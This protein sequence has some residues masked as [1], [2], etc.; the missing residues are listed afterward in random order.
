[1]G[2]TTVNANADA[3]TWETYAGNADTAPNSMR[4]RYNNTI[5]MNDWLMSPPM[6]FTTPHIYK[7]KFAYRANSATY[8]EK[9]TVYYGNAP[10]AAAMT[11]VI[12]E[13]LNITNVTYNVAEINIPIATSGTYYIG[14]WG[15]SAVD[16]FYIYLDTF[17]VS[18]ILD[19]I[20]PPLNLTATIQNNNNVHLAWQ[21]P[22]RALLGYK[23]YRDAALIATINNPA[24]LVYDDNAL[25]VG[26]YSYTVTAYYDGGESTPAGPVSVTIVPP[27]N[28]PTNLTAT[29]T[30]NDV[31]LNWTSPEA[32]PQGTWITWSQDVLGN[33]VGTNAAANFDVAHRWPVADIAPYV[34]QTISQVKFVPSEAN[35]VYTVKIWTGGSVTA[36]ATLVTSQV[37][38]NPTIDDW[39]LVVLNT[40]VTI[41]ANSEV[42]IGYNCNTQAGYPAGC[43]NGPQIENKGNMIY[44]SGSWS[45]LTALAPT[46]TYN[47]T[48]QGFVQ[49]STGMKAIT[50]KPVAEFASPVKNSGC[51]A[52]NHRVIEP[53]R[54]RALTG[55]KVYRDNVLVGT[56][57]NPT[58]T[59]FAE[60]DLP[61]ATYIYGVT[62]TY[63][64][65]E[66]V[67]ATVQAVVNV[68]LA[69]AFFTETFETYP[70][71]ATLF[72][73]WTLLDQDQSATYA[74]QN[75]EFP[76]SAGPM[77]FIIFNPSATTPPVTSVAAHGGAKMAA[78]FASTTPPNND[79][80]ITP[81]VHLGTTSAVKFYARSMSNTYLEDMRVGISTIATPIP[82]GFQTY[83]TGPNPV[84]V[85]A[86]WTEYIFDLAAY[87]G[88][89]IYLAIRNVSNDEFIFFVDDFTFHSVGGSVGNED[90][91]APAIATELK[92]N[93]PNPFNPETTISYSVKENTP[94]SVEIYNVKG[95][96]VKTLVNEAKAAGNYSVVWNGVDDNNR[97]VSSGV[98]FFKMSA[99]K[100]SST[101]KMIM[102]K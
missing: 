99:G 6:V 21:A 18:E 85:P 57:N 82:Q 101:K 14:F 16:M 95:Q 96:K 45:T 15:H 41:P 51:L 75:V 29:V 68:V 48:I 30:G 77:A 92:G 66:S 84:Q 38:N 28:P 24:T 87:D 86:A 35:C 80:L 60:N 49:T 10:T 54:N 71:F 31:V 50:N 81:R 63:T 46:L 33:S 53:N 76:G 32:P 39:N 3:Y 8:P 37:V 73:P 25:A 4:I 67:P 9:L 78:S 1:M 89:T 59:T 100:Y 93:Y 61:N 43:D 72:A 56:I 90:G 64:T 55:F 98:Y 17:S 40:P 11:N 62:A 79:W 83:L 102:M 12:F 69:P 27:N 42:W 36:P 52:L 5:D 97:P 94:V 26:T 2:W 88:Q 65:G 70:N 44:F 7:V 13:N 20:L 19:I 23:V 74:I 34:G 58:T 22:S 47:W 91:I